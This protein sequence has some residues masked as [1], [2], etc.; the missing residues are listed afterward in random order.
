MTS[1]ASRPSLVPAATSARSRSPVEMCGTCRC[2]LR[3]AACVPLPEPGA[4]RSTNRINITPRT[5]KFLRPRGGPAAA[6]IAIGRCPRRG[7]TLA[8]T[9]PRRANIAASLPHPGLNPGMDMP[10]GTLLYAQSGG[11][12]AVINA[13][14]AAR[15][16]DRPGP[17]GQGAGGPQRHPRRAARGA[18]RHLEGV[19]RGDPRP[20]PTPPAAP[21]A[22]A[23]S[24]SSRWS[25]TAPATSACWRCSR[26][27]T[28]AGSSTTAA[29]I[30]PTPRSRS[31]SWRPSST[32]R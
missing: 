27:T 1:L 20:W 11:V 29:T 31:R 32:T 18:D 22:R 17:Q 5:R 12:T 28:C 10:S 13:T 16:R 3:R 6:S 7:A 8:A 25:R 24:S 4:P 2:S 21:S 15:D 9:Q 26:P 14:A 23:G 19:G 30:R